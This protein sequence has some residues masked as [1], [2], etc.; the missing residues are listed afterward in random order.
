MI[1]IAYSDR[2]AGD[3]E[4]YENEIEAVQSD[5]LTSRQ[6][7]DGKP[8]DSSFP[9]PCVSTASPLLRVIN[10]LHIPLRNRQSTVRPSSYFTI[11]LYSIESL[12]KTGLLV[13][14]T[15]NI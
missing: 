9:S 14:S 10:K 1:T 2:Q 7:L 15:Q 13:L 11:C 3:N 4:E 8:L 12:L 6:L 5:G